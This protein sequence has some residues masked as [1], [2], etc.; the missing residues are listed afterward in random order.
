VGNNGNCRHCN[1]STVPTNTITVH[2]RTLCALVNFSAAVSIMMALQRHPKAAW[3]VDEAK[4]PVMSSDARIAMVKAAC[5]YLVA[6]F[7]E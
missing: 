2:N 4:K 6:Q 1:L 7:G 5:S 3:I